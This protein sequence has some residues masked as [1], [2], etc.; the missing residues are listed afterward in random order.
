[1]SMLNGL[2]TVRNTPSD[3]EAASTGRGS[4]NSVDMLV[5]IDSGATYNDERQAAQAYGS[6]ARA[7]LQKIWAW[8]LAF[9]FRWIMAISG[10]LS[11]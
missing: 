7:L 4:V 5:E 6:G 1:M 10:F 3:P 9:S 11:A 2:P 8:L